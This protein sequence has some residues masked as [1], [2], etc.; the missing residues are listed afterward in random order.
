MFKDNNNKYGLISKILHWFSA[1][2]I[3]GLYM[4]GKWMEDLDYYHEWYT[5]APHYHKSIGICLIVITI[6]RICWKVFTPSPAPINEHKKSLQLMAKLT[7]YGIYLLLFTAMISG[8]LI[9]TGDGRSIDVFNWFSVP[10]L[11]SFIEQQE[12]ITG[13]IHEQATNGVILLV[14]IHVIAALK[15]RFIDR[16]RSFYRMWR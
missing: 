15:H 2:I 14:I 8:Y 1:P 16:D 13:F 11:G 12:D 3:I 4:L 6:I 9:S 7:H 10:S 5:S